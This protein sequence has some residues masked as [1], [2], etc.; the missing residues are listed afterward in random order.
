MQYSMRAML[1]AVSGVAIFIGVPFVAAV[2][3]MMIVL[4]CVAVL[5]LTWSYLRRRLSAVLLLAGAATA[6]VM[7]LATACGVQVGVSGTDASVGHYSLGAGT[8]NIL[9]DWIPQ[10]SRGAI[11]RPPHI[12][13]YFVPPRNV[14]DFAHKLTGTFHFPLRSPLQHPRYDW[15]CNL[16]IWW[17]A[18]VL[19]VYPASVSVR[20]IRALRQGRP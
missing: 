11:H 20:C 10:P 13:F 3:T 14:E 17:L 7:A 12:G 18:A 8:G 16:P 1:A 6:G 15:V 9:F 2:A 4:L 5:P 19:I